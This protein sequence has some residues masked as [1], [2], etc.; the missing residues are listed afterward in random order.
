MEYVSLRYPGMSRQPR[1]Q[2]IPSDRGDQGNGPRRSARATKSQSRELDDSDAA[3]SRE[4][5]PA[6]RT[7]GS[8]NDDHSIRQTEVT[9]GKTRRGRRKV[10]QGGICHWL[11][12]P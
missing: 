5:R 3:S 10:N 7:S 6:Q 9:N 8:P 12:S 2:V 1:R 11:S 4:Q